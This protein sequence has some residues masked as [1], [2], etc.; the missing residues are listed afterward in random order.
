MTTGDHSVKPL[1]VSSLPLSGI[2]LIEASAGTGKTFNITRLYLRL[3]LESELSVTQILV[4]TFT[5]A[6]TQELRGRLTETLHNAKQYW[7]SATYRDANP[8][9]AFASLYANLCPEKS[10]LC[11]SLALVEMDEAAIYTLHGFCQ[12]VL[13]QMAFS[14]GNAL[15]F[16]LQNDQQKALQRSVDDWFRLLREKPDAL[17]LLAQSNWHTPD[18]FIR[19]FQPLIYATEPP[20]LADAETIERDHQQQLDDI[21]QQF[22]PLFK[23][24]LDSIT[25]ARASIYEGVIANQKKAEIQAQRAGELEQ[26]LN[27]L[28]SGQIEDIHG[29]VGAF[30]NGNR[31]RNNA[32]VKDVLKPIADMRKDLLAVV[33]KCQESTDKRRQELPLFELVAEGLAFVKSKIIAEKERRGELA[34]DDLIQLLADAVSAD[35]KI[36]EQLAQ[37]FPAALV[38]EFQ[39]TDALQYTIL[40]KV[41]VETEEHTNTRSLSSLLVMIGDP[42]QAIYGFRGGDIFT[43]LRARNNADFVWYMDT[44]W[45]STQA[46]INAYNRV[47][48]GNEL[49]APSQAVFGYEINYE[50]VKGTSFSAAAKRPMNNKGAGEDRKALTYVIADAE[51]MDI[52]DLSQKKA[53]QQEQLS[54]W[55]VAEIKRLL[56]SVRLGD[57]SVQ[58]SDIAILVRNRIEA[59]R[60]SEYLRLEGLTAVYLSDKTSLFASAQAH[61]LQLLLNGIWYCEN[62]SELIRALS[63]ALFGVKPERLAEMQDDPQALAWSEL[64][65]RA[66]DYRQIWREQGI[67]PLLFDLLKT[68]Y[69]PR[70]ES[71][72]ELTNYV[73]LVELLEQAS[74]QHAHPL[75]ILQWLRAKIDHI[76][77]DEQFEQRLE[78]D[79]GLIKIVTQHKSKGLEYPFVFVPYVNEYRDP[80]MQ[81]RSV[82]RIF[83]YFEPDTQSQVWQLGQSQQAIELL[84]DQEHAESIRLLYVAITRA[85]YQCY[86][87]IGEY[88]DSDKSAIGLALGKHQAPYTQMSWH[89]FLGRLSEI[90]ANECDLKMASQLPD[91]GQAQQNQTGNPTLEVRKFDRQLDQKWRVHSFSGLTRFSDHTSRTERESESSIAIEREKES[92]VTDMRFSFPKGA[93]PGNFIHDVFEHTDFANPDWLLQCEAMNL[94]Y[95]LVPQEQLPQIGD[96]FD[97][98]INAPI[99]LQDDYSESV[100]MSQL[101][102]ENTLREAEFYFPITALNSQHLIEILTE[103]RKALCQKGLLSL[104]HIEA[105]LQLSRSH[106]EGMMHGFIDLIFE[107]GGKFYVADYKSTYLG[108]S[109]DDYLPAALAENNL[110]HAYDLQ[111]LIYALALH[112]YLAQQLPD[113]S[114]ANHFGGVSYLYVRGMQAEKQCQNSV[115][116]VFFTELDAQTLQSL[117]DAF[118]GQN[119][120]ES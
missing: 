26:V 112:R 81:N 83:R 86:L 44:N 37:T 14:T 22:G 120:G 107:H 48:W 7:Q 38:D 87:G 94:K 54:L 75:Q 50:Q 91:S 82:R 118:A 23:Q 36:A 58:P 76:E 1:E 53:I 51:S 15:Q 12:R 116:G 30:L 40:S 74:R 43:Y 32:V 6:A 20:I 67:M 34:F 27:W 52:D 89:E 24:H 111:Y 92:S 114:P 100:K 102:L 101:Q 88:P 9:P 5:N 4:M 65:K 42:K 84:R 61:D 80:A 110:V 96:W 77:S 95:A 109:L 11:L 2:H 41:Y 16:T 69:Q 19:N 108:S 66:Y 98:V 31:Y 59:E 117:D 56:N 29:D 105:P 45:R 85:E 103:H 62:D 106:I 63:S 47:F 28:G 64:R 113:Y 18:A 10:I 97:A 39:D 8:D 79:A 73:H 70:N 57:D 49:D 33:K 68:H 3:L 17:A 104:N 78:S 119:K 60:I 55:C 90:S 25:H 21:S 46:M 99:C 72:R 115:T 71:E 13:K 35:T 93:T